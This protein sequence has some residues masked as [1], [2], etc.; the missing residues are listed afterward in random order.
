MIQRE[1]IKGCGKPIDPNVHNVFLF[2]EERYYVAMW[3]IPLAKALG[4]FGMGGNIT[5][6]LW[7]DQEV[8]DRW[9]VQFRFRHYKDEKAFD[10]ADK[11]TWYSAESIGTEQ[12]VRTKFEEMLKIATASSIMFDEK[13]LQ[14]HTFE[15]NCDGNK[16]IEI[17][18]N[19]PPFWMKGQAQL[20]E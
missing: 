19:R 4:A 2:L 9:C 5:A 10:S 17:L 16:V 15:L 7:R 11:R 8:P 1:I 6:L 12:E 14:L 13:P 3:Y 20:A 18:Q